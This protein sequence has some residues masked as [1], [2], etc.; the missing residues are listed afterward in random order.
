MLK[1]EPCAAHEAYT[2]VLAVS[3]MDQGI[4]QPSFLRLIQRVY[5]SVSECAHRIHRSIL[6]SV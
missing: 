4:L 6:V 5:G 1:A 3:G 2:D